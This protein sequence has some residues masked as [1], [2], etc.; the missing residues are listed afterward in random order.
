MVDVGVWKGQ[1]TINMAL[2][3]KSSGMDGCVIAVD[4]FLGSPE[5]W[6]M[7]LFDRKNGFP[8]LYWVFMS[9][10]IPA[11][12]A[13]YIVPVAQT[14]VTAAHIFKQR[15]RALLLNDAGYADIERVP[16]R[17]V[18]GDLTQTHARKRSPSRCPMPGCRSA[19][20]QPSVA[21]RERRRIREGGAF[22]RVTVANEKMAVGDQRS[23]GCLRE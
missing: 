18:S 15:A 12:A 4:T 13:D 6:D 1:S 17:S 14:S 22:K 7:K 10:A 5:H 16:V 20:E 21:L 9:N 8:D 2:A 19:P 11:G 23:P 3:M